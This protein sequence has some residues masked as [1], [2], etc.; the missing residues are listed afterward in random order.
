MSGAL[1]VGRIGSGIQIS[2]SFQENAVL[3]LQKGVR[4]MGLSGG[5]PPTHIKCFKALVAGTPL[6]V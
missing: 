4:P 3:K 6:G 1:V 2:A 5:W